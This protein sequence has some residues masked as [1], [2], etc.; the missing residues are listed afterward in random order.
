VTLRLPKSSLERA[1]KAQVAA[2]PDPKDYEGVER[3][4]RELRAAK[5]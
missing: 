4:L 3:A 2:R 5:D 1:L